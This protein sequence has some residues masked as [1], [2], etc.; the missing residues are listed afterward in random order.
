[1]PATRSIA[2]PAPAQVPRPRV[3]ITHVRTADGALVTVATFLGPV[4]YVLHNGSADPVLPR[5]GWSAPG[6][7]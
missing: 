5:R 6:Q 7:P 4:R 1:V 2:A 3:R